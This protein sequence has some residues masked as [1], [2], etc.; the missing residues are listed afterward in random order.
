MNDTSPSQTIRIARCEVAG[1]SFGLDLSSIVGIQPREVIHFEEADSNQVIGTIASM[2]RKLPVYALAQLLGM[3]S[4]RTRTGHCIVATDGVDVW[5]LLVDRVS[6]SESRTASE[7]IPL[8]ALITGSAD[9]MILGVVCNTGD[10]GPPLIVLN[11]KRLRPQQEVIS[12]EVVTSSP[13]PATPD[14]PAMSMESAQRQF[15]AFTPAEVDEDNLRYAFSVRQVSEITRVPNSVPLPGAPDFVVGLAV[16]R[17]GPLPIVRL[18]TGHFGE[19][20]STDLTDRIAIVKVPE[21]EL[22]LGVLVSLDCELLSCPLVGTPVPAASIDQ[23]QHRIRAAFQVGSQT[24]LFPLFAV[25]GG[26][27]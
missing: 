2:G 24:L 7:V 8:P 15:L 5:G 18:D 21:C 13:M 1:R 3:A 19:K 11:L 16:W 27:A 17:N 4:T 14:Q 20:L 9:S 25:N 6:H 23:P 22:P 10:D 26:F 12:N